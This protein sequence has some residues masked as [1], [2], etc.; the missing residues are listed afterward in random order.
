MRYEAIYARQSV[1]KADSISIESQIEICKKEVRGEYKVYTDKGYSGKNTDR[2]ELLKMMDHI[3][4]GRISKVI[5]Y[6]LD[7][8]SRS[9]LDFSSMIQVFQTNNV[10]FVS[11]ME[12]FDTSSPI[13]NAMLMII[14]V[15]AQLERETIQR[16]VA[17]AYKSRCEK[18]FYM[19]GRVP[20]G[21]Q[22]K[23]AVIDG[24]KTKMYAPVKEEL[25]W[26][27]RMFEYYSHPRTSL[28]DVAYMLANEGVKSKTGCEI[29]RSYVRDILINPIYAR[30]DLQLY[31]FLKTNGVRFANQKEDFIGT[32]GGYLYSDRNKR[33]YRS[34]SLDGLLLVLAPHEGVIESDVWI[35][36]RKKCMNN[37][38]VAKPT[39]AK[40][41]W[42]AGKIKCARCG[43]ALVH[44]KETYK[45]ATTGETRIKRY[46]LCSHKYITHT[47][48]FPSIDAD[49][50][51]AA[52]LAEMKKKIGELRSVEINRGSTQKSKIAEL[53]GKVLEIDTE[54]D[55]LLN[56]VSSAT[57][58]VMDYIN[59]KVESLDEEKQKVLKE[60]SNLMD[61]NGPDILNLENALDN[62]DIYSFED[63]M[64]IVDCLIE[65]I[66][67][68][69]GELTIRWKI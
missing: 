37:T 26:V 65:S 12:K 57:K 28:G 21:F 13:G 10:E 19:G 43:Y 39:K 67:A 6:R 52:V 1:D 44:K 35:R 4:S 9:V 5:V 59:K 11:S 34:T 14:M 46:Y 32:N 55:N 29:S 56:K 30:F 47:C 25:C 18:G 48:S 24:V 31:N 20:F 66:H 22:L 49:Q 33:K 7:R 16:R 40:A 60:I 3:Q 69:P 64:G 50:L 17:D 27:S 45:L 15:F 58:T 2:P 42:L 63:K 61:S 54:I 51:D 62:W 41:T 36:C 53:Q 8:I 38:A 23:E 68:Q